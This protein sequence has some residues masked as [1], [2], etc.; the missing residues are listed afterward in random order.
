MEV[1]VALKVTES[2]P[3]DVEDSVAD[4]VEFDPFVVVGL[5][6]LMTSNKVL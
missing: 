5:T 3:V 2:V 6:P 4:A 1:P